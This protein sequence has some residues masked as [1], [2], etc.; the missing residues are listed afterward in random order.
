MKKR[1]S[2]AYKLVFLLIVAAILPLMLFGMV[3]LWQARTTA[4]RAVIVGNYRIAERAANEIN[5]YVTKTLGG[6]R[7][8]GEDVN[9][10]DLKQWQRQRTLRNVVLE[11]PEYREITIF[12]SAKQV[13]ATS[14]IGTPRLSHVPLIN[15]AISRALNGD[16]YMSAVFITEELTPAMIAAFPLTHLGSITDVI[17]IELDMLHM[18]R[19]VDGVKIGESGYLNVV[20]PNGKLVASGSGKLKKL[21][22]Q[23]KDYPEF[24]LLSHGI[25]HNGTEPG[26]ATR[27]DGADEL[28]ISA[29]HL[30]P[31]L[32]WMAIVEQP[33][34]E[35]YF[36][37]HRMTW[38]LIILATVFVISMCV[39]G[40][41]GGKW[42]VLEPIKALIRGTRAVSSGNLQYRVPENRGDEFGELAKSF[43]QM[44]GDL[45]L[46]QDNIRRNERMAMFGRIASGLV[47]DLKHPVKSI[48]NASRLMNRMYEDPDYRKTFTKTVEREF[49]KI[50]S[51]LSNLHTLTH[52][53]PYN[54]LHLKLK[55]L[56][57]G[58]VE[59]FETQATAESK[60]II[61]NMPDDDI[62][63]YADKMSITRALS[64]IVINGIQA[65]TSGGR[66]TIEAGRRKDDSGD[67]VVLKINDTGCGIS[68]ARVQSI[69]GDFVT[70]KRRGL[71]LGLALTKRILDQHGA[72]IR[73]QSEEGVGTSFEISF[74]VID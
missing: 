2:I 68:P 58:I 30:H 32:G 9:H 24:N 52:D 37:V 65:M 35:A 42:Q 16:A 27:I 36:L 73:V 39:I 5:Q 25:I 15:E 31:P 38:Q 50:N 71:G 7:L 6:A 21:V 12:D 4:E 45:M 22:L 62:I 13:V 14:A 64:N 26:Y 43:N 10:S 55:P 70:T 18:W 23:E 63:I 56:I 33:S 48:E 44:T 8:I 74:P 20:L 17:S 54:P 46:M 11:F 3:S 61:L 40:Y 67:K 72:G 28:L 59:T 49:E 29:A 34:G 53:I 47:H 69:F 60:E 41:F 57:R 19:L 51:F 1:F 66:L